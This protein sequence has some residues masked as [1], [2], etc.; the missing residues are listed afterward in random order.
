MAA[1]KLVLETSYLTHYN[2]FKVLV[3]DFINEYISMFDYDMSHIND[4]INNMST[5][6][7][8]LGAYKCGLY[9]K[10]KKMDF[11]NTDLVIESLEQQLDI[12]KN[13]K[14]FEKSINNRYNNKFDI[15]ITKS[16]MSSD[17]CVLRI[18][19]NSKDMEE[20]DLTNYKA[21]TKSIKDFNL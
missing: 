12:F 5:F 17:T 20:L 9:F 11:E 18:S 16:T 8:S 6:D 1:D 4:K 2:D 21:S 19:I 10:Y 15:K 7:I 3:K 14:K 13:L